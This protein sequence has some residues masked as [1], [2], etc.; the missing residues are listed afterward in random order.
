MLKHIVANPNIINP[1][2]HDIREGIEKLL[3]I[4]RRLNERKSNLNMGIGSDTGKQEI[5]NFKEQVIQLKEDYAAKVKTPEEKTAL[6]H[7]LN[8]VWHNL[9]ILG[10][11][12]H[13]LKP[14]SPFLHFSIYN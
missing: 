4:N 3:E 14:T 5:I 11:I 7:Y 8:N 1:L 13:K 12:Y 2:P 10:Y 9:N 6:S